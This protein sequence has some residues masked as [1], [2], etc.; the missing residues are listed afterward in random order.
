MRLN[1]FARAQNCRR[2]AA[3]SRSSDGCYIAVRLAGLVFFLTFTILKPSCS[4]ILGTMKID[5]FEN[6]MSIRLT[7][8]LICTALTAFISGGYASSGYAASYNG[9]NIV[10]MVSAFVAIGFRAEPQQLLHRSSQLRVTLDVPIAFQDAPLLSAFAHPDHLLLVGSRGFALLSPSS[11][12]KYNGYTFSHF[13]NQVPAE[14]LP[15]FHGDPLS[16]PLKALTSFRQSREV[17]ETLAEITRQAE[18]E[19]RRRQKRLKKHPPAAVRFKDAD[20]ILVLVPDNSENEESEEEDIEDEDD[21]YLSTLPFETDSDEEERTPVDP[22]EQLA[23][24][25]SIQSEPSKVRIIIYRLP[26]MRGCIVPPDSPWLASQSDEGT[27]DGESSDEDDSDKPCDDQPTS[28]DSV[29]SGVAGSAE[30]SLTTECRVETVTATIIP[31][32]GAE[33]AFKH[34]LSTAP[35]GVEV[36]TTHDYQRNT[37]ESSKAESKVDLTE[38]NFHGL[39]NELI[40]KYIKNATDWFTCDYRQCPHTRSSNMDEL[41]A[42]KRIFLRREYLDD[43]DKVRWLMWGKLEDGGIFYLFSTHCQ[44]YEICHGEGGFIHIASDWK[45]LIDSFDRCDLK[46]LVQCLC[47][48]EPE[49]T[50]CLKGDYKDDPDDL[51]DACNEY[52]R[53]RKQELLKIFERPEFR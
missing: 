8:S 53:D 7:L 16:T 3:F 35:K 21:L 44:S 41:K 2:D 26:D 1:S 50:D 17:G 37:E 38:N 33:E 51:Y 36:V 6:I 45:G 29:D 43:I 20:I 47:K 30:S 12:L 46:E 39:F 10:S 52:D 28:E 24:E 31:G 11:I 5:A 34:W 42:I 19:K 14:L 40:K 15:S 4:L 25:L 18:A 48:K 22:H 49:L 23:T 13:N 32:S 9:V 27:G